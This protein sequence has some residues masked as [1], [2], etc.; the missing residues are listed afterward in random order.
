MFDKFRELRTKEEQAN[1]ME[2]AE[3]AN[4]V[5]VTL[6]EGIKGLDN[7]DVFF[8][9][10][11]QVGASHKRIPGFKVDYFWK[12]EKPFLEAV[13]TTLGDRYTENVENIYKIT[14]KFI[15]ETLV[16]GFDSAKVSKVANAT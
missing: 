8:E 11:H 14:I 3:H 16:K 5:M 6:D 9:Y 13:E 2:L 10:L 7:L 15:I 12:I 4:R 1:S